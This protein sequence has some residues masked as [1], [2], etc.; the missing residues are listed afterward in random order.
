M[1]FTEREYATLTRLVD[2]IIPADDRSGS[3]SEAGVPAYIDFTAL[4]GDEPEEL[5]VRLRGGLAWLDVQ[6]ARRFGSAF[7]DCEEAQCTALLD[8]IAYPD[9]VEPGMEA[10]AA[11]FSLVRDLTASGFYSSEAGIKDLQYLGNR[12]LATWEGAPQEVLDRAGVSYA[13][14][15]SRAG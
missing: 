2:F 4:D 9:D 5:Q 3:A 10:G 13:E 12:A 15:E 1:F 14:W 8:R 7:V 11:F 6:C